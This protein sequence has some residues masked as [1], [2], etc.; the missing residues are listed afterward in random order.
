MRCSCKTTETDDF[1][2]H[3]AIAEVAQNPSKLETRHLSWQE[4]MARWPKRIWT[5]MF[6]YGVIFVFFPLLCYLT[7]AWVNGTSY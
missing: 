1:S 4:I 7:Y 3:V 2:Q 5:T 6:T